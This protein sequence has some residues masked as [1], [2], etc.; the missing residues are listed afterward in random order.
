MDSHGIGKHFEILIEMEKYFRKLVGGEKMFLP[1][2]VK[3]IFFSFL[4]AKARE[5]FFL[6]RTS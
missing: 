1:M 3:Y 4:K 6:A 2:D 5:E